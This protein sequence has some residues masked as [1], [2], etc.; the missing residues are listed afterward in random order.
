MDSKSLWQT[1]VLAWG[2]CILKKQ[3]SDLLE[4]YFFQMKSAFIFTELPPKPPTEIKNIECLLDTPIYRVYLDGEELTLNRSRSIQK[5]YT[6]SNLLTD[7]LF[8]H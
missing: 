1:I 5:V 4:G 2:L 8:F 6:Y 7:L 3:E